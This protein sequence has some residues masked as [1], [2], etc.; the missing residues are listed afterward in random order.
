MSDKREQ[1][2]TVLGAQM[3][4]YENERAW[5]QQYYAENETKIARLQEAKQTIQQSKENVEAYANAWN[6]IASGFEADIDWQGTYKNDILACMG[7]AV[8]DDYNAYIRN[9]D[10]VLDAICDEMTRLE[11][12][13]WQTM[14]II[15]QLSALI[16]SLWNEITKL[17]N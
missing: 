9:I 7:T 2:R 16:N 13:N 10:A 15:G 3:G 11:N 6:A 4:Q 5:Q 17:F 14:G 1:L 8:Q 12:E